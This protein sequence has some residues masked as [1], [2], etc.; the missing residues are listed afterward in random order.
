MRMKQT[1]NNIWN[2]RESEKKRS[3]DGDRKDSYSVI[4]QS[5]CVQQSAGC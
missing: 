4:G 2:I 1:R 5:Q 3:G